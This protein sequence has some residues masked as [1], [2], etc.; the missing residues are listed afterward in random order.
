M[1]EI[2]SGLRYFAKRNE[3]VLCEMVLCEMVL[4]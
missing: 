4:W 1:I 2:K 3:T